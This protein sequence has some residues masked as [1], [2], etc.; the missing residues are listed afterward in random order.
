MSQNIASLL[1][2]QGHDSVYDHDI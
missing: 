1:V 2:L